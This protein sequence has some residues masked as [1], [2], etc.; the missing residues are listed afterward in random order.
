MVSY[1]DSPL[2]FR[3]GPK[4]VMDADTL[5]VVFVSADPYTRRYDLDIVAEEDEA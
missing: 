4:S 1:F 5:A 3:H 2:G